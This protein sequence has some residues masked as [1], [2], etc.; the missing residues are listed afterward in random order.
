[1]IGTGAQG[2]FSRPAASLE[3]LHADTPHARGRFLGAFCCRLNPRQQRSGEGQQ[4]FC[5][6]PC[7]RPP[8]MSER[9]ETNR[10]QYAFAACAQKWGDRNNPPTPAVTTP[11]LLQPSVKALSHLLVR[12]MVWPGLLPPAHRAGNGIGQRLAHGFHRPVAH[13]QIPVEGKSGTQRWGT[14]NIDHGTTKLM[15]GHHQYVL[16]LGQNTRSHTRSQR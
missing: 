11:I 12:D 16:P 5:A 2:R 15:T 3:L 4:P 6:I 14:N 8:R 13:F 9:L 10:I 1:M 7:P